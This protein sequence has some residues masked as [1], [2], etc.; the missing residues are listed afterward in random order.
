MTFG[1]ECDAAI[2]VHL[3]T[4]SASHVRDSSQSRLFKV[5]HML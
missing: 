2:M 4:I 1:S 5:S 3:R